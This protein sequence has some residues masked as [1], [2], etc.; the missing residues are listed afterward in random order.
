MPLCYGMLL[1]LFLMK[2]YNSGTIYDTWYCLIWYRPLPAGLRSC[3]NDMIQLSIRC[4]FVMICCYA[5]FSWKHIIVVRY[6]IPGIVWYDNDL[7]RQAFE[8]AIWYNAITRYRYSASLYHMSLRFFLMKTYHSGTI[9]DIFWYDAD[10]CRGTFEPAIWYDT[11]IDKMPLYLMLI[12][13]RLLLMKTYNSGTI[14]D[15]FWYDTDLYRHAF[16]AAIWYYTIIDIMHLCI[17]CC[18]AYFS[19][20]CIIVVRYMILVFSDALASHENI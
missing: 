4:P 2:T 17:I 13:V 1:R 7:Y 12:Q 6:M 11:I 3:S 18:Y 16:E 15:I 14:H 20:K 5:Y 10:L 19:W 9:H 8:A